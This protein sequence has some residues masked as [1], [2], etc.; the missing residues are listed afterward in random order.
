MALAHLHKQQKT[1]C[2]IFIL[3]LKVLEPRYFSI[4]YTAQLEMLYYFIEPILEE[5]FK[6]S[7][8]ESL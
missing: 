7:K 8:N 4:L 6:K 2:L 1:S 5:I 3:E